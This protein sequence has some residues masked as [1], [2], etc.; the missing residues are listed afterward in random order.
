MKWKKFLEKSLLF[1][2]LVLVCSTLISVL[3]AEFVVRKFFPQK[4]FYLAQVEGLHVWG[5]GENTPFTLQKN[6]KNS[7]HLGFTHEFDHRVNTNSFGFRGPEITQ[8]KTENVYRILMLGDSLPFGWGV[9]DDQTYPYLLEKALNENSQNKKYE[10]INA[11]L[12][13]GRTLDSYLVWLK[14]QGFSFAPD[15]VIVNFFPWNDITDLMSMDWI[16]TDE[17]GLPL[18]VAS[19]TE[20]VKNGSLAWKVNTNWMY[21]IPVLRN[22]HLGILLLT[23]LENKSAPTAE[24]IKQKL[25]ISSPPEVYKETDKLGCLYSLQSNRCPGKILANF[26]KAEL[27]LESLNQV[28][29]EKQIKFLVTIMPAPDQAIPLSINFN[30]QQDL[31][32]SQPQKRIRD[33]LQKNNILY[34]DLL[35][36]MSDPGA[37]SYFYSLDGHPNYEGYRQISQTLYDFLRQNML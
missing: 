20:T 23:A 26:T 4:T 1:G 8:K 25:N 34:L 9:E 2:L 16:K 28:C 37:K 30:R 14:D 29:R 35:G 31:P 21:Q 27:L 6:I 36:A 5:Q 18:A 12:T 22:S 13:S 19:R 32:A 3:T 7:R 17:Q 24:K 33:F 15:L 11:G 10:V